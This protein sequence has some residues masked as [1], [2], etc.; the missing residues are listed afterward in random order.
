MFFL[1]L[2]P[3]ILSSLLMAAHVFRAGLPFLAFLCLAAPLLLLTQR[4]W[5]VR[6]IQILLV[7]Y[8]IEWLRTLLLLVQL[9]MEHNLPWA[10]LA[11]I[12]GSVALFSAL[13]A[14]VF[15]HPALRKKWTTH[16]PHP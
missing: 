11:I 7:L 16:P 12:L 5:S 10:R 4:L 9:R 8:G 1:Y 13:S 15:R 14:L 3:V 2:L 6:V